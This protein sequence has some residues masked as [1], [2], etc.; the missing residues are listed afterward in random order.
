MGKVAFLHELLNKI[1]E[2][3][4]SPLVAQRALWRIG[5]G[6]IE[7]DI[8]DITHNLFDWFCEFNKTQLSPEDQALLDLDP[9]TIEDEQER[10]QALRRQAKA[11]KRARSKNRTFTSKATPE[12]VAKVQQILDLPDHVGAADKLF[13]VAA[14]APIFTPN[15]LVDLLDRVSNTI[16]SC[17]PSG[18]LGATQ[19]VIQ[20]TLAVSVYTDRV[21]AAEAL[22]LLSHGPVMPS[23]E[24]HLKQQFAVMRGARRGQTEYRA[25]FPDYV[26]NLGKVPV[27]FTYDAFN[28]DDRFW[29][30]I[31]A[32]VPVEQ[33]PNARYKEAARILSDCV[34]FLRPRLVEGQTFDNI[35][36]IFEE[37]KAIIMRGDFEYPQY[38]F[39]DEMI[40]T[41][42]VQLFVSMNELKENGTFM[43]NCTHSMYKSIYKQGSGVLYRLTDAEGNVYNSDFRPTGARNAWVL[44]ETKGRRN[45]IVTKQA[46]K[47]ANAEILRR[48]NRGI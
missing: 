40:G 33:K 11:A 15:E 37:R 31:A 26:R 41:V 6:K 43:G 45:Q 34:A 14:C 27:D 39:I 25:A 42:L 32:R 22:W 20:D 44:R 12:L 21:T 17:S 48:L 35:E 29:E 28:A 5:R 23:H 10:K 9:D 4:Q 3:Q 7:G 8:K 36:D 16:P 47:D 1:E 19:Q 24:N 30:R 13:F 18:G 2:K 38:A 46:V